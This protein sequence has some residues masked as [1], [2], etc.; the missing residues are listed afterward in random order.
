VF[1]SYLILLHDLSKHLL[2]D[3]AL[4]FVRDVHR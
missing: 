2:V 1:S 3:K 4:V